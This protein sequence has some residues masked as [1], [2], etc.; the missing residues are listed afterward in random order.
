MSKVYDVPATVVVREP[1]QSLFVMEPYEVCQKVGWHS[2]ALLVV[3]NVGFP[4][5]RY[6]TE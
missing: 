3:V 2:F 1:E 4:T 5:W 6:D